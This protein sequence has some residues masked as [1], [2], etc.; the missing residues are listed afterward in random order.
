MLTSA[1]TKERSLGGRAVLLVRYLLRNNTTKDKDKYKD[2][3][4]DKDKYK[5]KDKDKVTER[6]NMCYIFEN[7]M[8][9]GCQI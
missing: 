9:Q 4:K 2:K 3:D 7:Y 8:T 5:D 1:D 6:P